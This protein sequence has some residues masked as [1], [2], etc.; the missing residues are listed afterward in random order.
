MFRFWNRYY[1]IIIFVADKKG[2]NKVEETNESEVS[3]NVLLSAVPLT[4]RTCQ[5]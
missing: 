1:G 5:P 3:S 2:Y 4:V